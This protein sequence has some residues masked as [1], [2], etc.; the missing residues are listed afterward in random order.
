MS[1]LTETPEEREISRDREDQDWDPNAIR[2]DEGGAEGAPARR[3]VRARRL[4]CQRGVRHKTREVP[5][6]KDLVC[7]REREGGPDQ[8]KSDPPGVAIPLAG[9]HD[10]SEP[11]REQKELWPDERTNTNHHRG[12]SRKAARVSRPAREHNETPTEPREGQAT[13]ETA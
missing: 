9:E 8:T 11:D 5:H 3:P 6:A 12:P 1:L 10:A 13:L 2:V 4:L 7:E